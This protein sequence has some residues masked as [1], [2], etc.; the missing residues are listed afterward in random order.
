MATKRDYYDVLGVDRDA[1]ADEIKKA[2]RKLAL[3]HHPDK[4]QGD[5]ESEERF[6]EINEAYEILCDEE[7]RA[8]YDRFGHEGVGAQGGGYG[9]GF[10]DIFNDFFGD[11]FSH[12]NKKTKQR[13]GEDLRYAVKI[14]FEEA[15]QGSSKEIKFNRYEKCASCDG[16]G[17][18]NGT[19]PVICPVCKGTGE[20][21]QQQGFFTVSRTC[22]KCKGEGEFIEN[23]CPVCKGDGRVIKERKLDIKI[24]AGIDDGNRLKVSGEGASGIYGGPSGD[25]YVD[26]TVEPHRIFKR[27]DSDIFVGVPISFAQAALGCEVEV[28]TIDGKTTIKIPS[29][30]Q[31]GTQFTL[32]G[33]GAPRLNSG[34][35]GNEYVNIVVETP[36]NLTLKQKR[37]LEEFALESGEK[38]HPLKKSFIDK[39]LSINSN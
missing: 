15:M 19:K 14:K 24:P 36:T 13:R 11:I 12:S 34:I 22:Y 21:R 3:K 2:Y 33:K 17:A 39:I 6:K 4:N 27:E 38:T 9:F 5:G 32:K 8:A 7:K 26:V 1:T 25:L 29:G 37:L 28:P 20:I 10:S 35:K 31:S 23:P 30:T 16:T 18:K